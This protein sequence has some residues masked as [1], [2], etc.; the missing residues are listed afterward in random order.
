RTGFLLVTPRAR[1][2]K[3]VRFRVE[4]EDKKEAEGGKRA[5][6]LAP[7]GYHV[8]S[9]DQSRGRGTQVTCTGRTTAYSRTMSH[10]KNSRTTALSF[11]SRASMALACAST[12]SAVRGNSGFS[13]RGNATCF[14]MTSL[15]EQSTRTTRP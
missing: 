9:K 3:E 5:A 11:R 1:D 10:F 7:T 2:E 4:W 14:Q 13:G 15:P 12:A 6:G 8:E